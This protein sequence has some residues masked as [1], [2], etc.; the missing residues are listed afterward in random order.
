VECAVRCLGLFKAIPTW[1][2]T[3]ITYNRRRAG[4]DLKGT[5]RPRGESPDGRVCSG[6]PTPYGAEHDS[7][8]HHGRR[9][10]TKNRNR[11]CEVCSPRLAGPQDH[12]NENRAAKD[13]TE[14]ARGTRCENAGGSNPLGSG[15]AMPLDPA[16]KDGLIVHRPARVERDEQ[17]D[18]KRDGPRG[19]VQGM[20]R[21][22]QD[23]EH[24]STEAQSKR[25]AREDC[26]DG[27]NRPH[28]LLRQHVFHGSFPQRSRL[29][30][31]P[32]LHGGCGH[33]TCVSLVLRQ[34]AGSWPVARATSQ[35]N[36]RRRPARH[37]G[38][39]KISKWNTLC[40]QLAYQ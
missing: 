26:E 11:L 23:S 28:I 7:H 40:P 34:S 16:L 8:S 3:L 13:E 18:R 20:R 36:R 14:E 15:P 30:L 32:R 6:G 10:H 33:S 21:V 29:G 9:W 1:E 35:H 38:G 17:P 27:P 37:R 12:A 31:H 22:R 4:V 19:P 39:G 24:G 25:D 5:R 2:S